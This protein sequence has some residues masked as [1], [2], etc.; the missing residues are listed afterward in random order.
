[1]GGINPTV[2]CHKEI[3][4]VKLG[5]KAILI[6]HNGRI[7]ARHVGLYLGQDVVQEIVVMDFGVEEGGAFRRW[8]EVITRIPFWLS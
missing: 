3:G 4:I 5:N 1:M 7:N 6:Q 2:F 8:E